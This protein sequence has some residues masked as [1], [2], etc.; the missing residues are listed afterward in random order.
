MMVIHEMDQQIRFQPSGWGKEQEGSRLED[1]QG[2]MVSNLL[3]SAQ[4][5]QLR[6]IST[7]SRR[8]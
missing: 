2:P 7:I 6:A 8:M 4:A 1:V 3:A 5:A